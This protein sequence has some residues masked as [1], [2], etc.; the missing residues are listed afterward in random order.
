MLF[1]LKFI[2]FLGNKLGQKAKKKIITRGAKK[3]KPTLTQLGRIPPRP[4]ARECH[5]VI[6][7]GGGVGKSALAIQ[8][9]Q[10]TFI[11]AYDPTIEDAYRRLLL[12]DGVPVLFDILDTAGQEEFSSMQDQWFSNGE[13]FIL[14]Y[15]TT[16]KESYNQIS[17]YIEK[18]LRVKDTDCTPA[19]LVGSKCDCVVG[20]Q[21]STDE[22]TLFAKKHTLPFFEVSSKLAINVQ[23]VFTTAVRCIWEGRGMT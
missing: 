23:E 6:V 19:V 3:L 7:G 20:R 15:S 2:L 18:I 11:L 1:S 8:F 14:V 4:E 22:A 13:V 17:Q 10:N 9:I 21:V 16:C 5:G 12:V